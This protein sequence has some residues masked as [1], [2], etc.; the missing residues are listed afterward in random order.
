MYTKMLNTGT[1]T[2]ADIHITNKQNMIHDT[3]NGLRIERQKLSD[4]IDF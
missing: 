3:V 1:G 4:L 2:G